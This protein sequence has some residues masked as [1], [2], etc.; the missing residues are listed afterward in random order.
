MHSCHVAIVYRRVGQKRLNRIYWVQS[1]IN[2]RK[3]EMGIFNSYCLNDYSRKKIHSLISLEC[4]IR[5]LTSITCVN[6]N[7]F[8]NLKSKTHDAKTVD[9][10]RTKN[11][12]I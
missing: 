3:I 8:S 7:F 4:L 9:N 11:L 5:L 2:E 12:K 1:P 10:R 6:N